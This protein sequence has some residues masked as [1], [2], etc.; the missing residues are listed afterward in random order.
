V[1][2]DDEL[3]LRETW[4][5]LVDVREVVEEVVV[6]AGTDPVRVAVTA[7]VGRD[8]MDALREPLGDLAPAVTEIEEAVDEQIRR[9]DRR[10]S[11]PFEDV[12][13]EPARESEMP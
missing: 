3:L 11:V 6:T 1:T 13:G 9:V 12:I 7:Q 10:R 5:Q 2:D 8:D 4:H